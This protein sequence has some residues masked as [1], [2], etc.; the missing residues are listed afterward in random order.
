M[1]KHSG[2][3]RDMLLEA[4]EKIRKGYK[5]LV[6][7]EGTRSPKGG[8]SGVERGTC[9]A[10]EERGRRRGV[11]GSRGGRRLLPGRGPQR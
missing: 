11:G 4:T 9:G 1:L 8:L 10:R 5:F 2:G 3:D 6:F 7:P